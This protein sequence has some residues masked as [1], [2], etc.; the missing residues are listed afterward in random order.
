[1]SDKSRSFRGNSLLLR[2]MTRLSNERQ[3]RIREFQVERVLA[4]LDDENLTTQAALNLRSSEGL[5]FECNFVEN[6]WQDSRV[7]NR[8]AQLASRGIT[9]DVIEHRSEVGGQAM[10]RTQIRIAF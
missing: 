8:V 3:R 10:T 7:V 4:I 5:V 2:Q 6:V 9:A 1:M